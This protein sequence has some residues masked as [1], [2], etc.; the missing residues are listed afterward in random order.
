MKVE[1]LRIGSE[2]LDLY[3]AKA[4]QMRDQE[5]SRIAGVVFQLPRRLLLRASRKDIHA[6]NLVNRANQSGLIWLF[7]CLVVWLFG[8]L[9]VWL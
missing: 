8:C 7:G 3:I 1:R 9:V 6:I 2:E 5:I 4:K